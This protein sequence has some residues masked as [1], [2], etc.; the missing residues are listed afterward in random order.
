MSIATSNVSMLQIDYPPSAAQIESAADVPLRSLTVQEPAQWIQLWIQRQRQ[1][2]V[3]WAQLY[4]TVASHE[5]RNTQAFKQIE[6]YYDRLFAGTKFLYEAIEGKHKNI[7]DHVSAEI[8]AV[9][10][11]QETFAR[12]VQPMITKHTVDTIAKKR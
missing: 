1:A 7:D 10:K 6:A 8:T 4:N 5:D 12:E 9:V 11:S 3:G 2:E